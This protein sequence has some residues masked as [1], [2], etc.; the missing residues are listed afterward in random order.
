MLNRHWVDLTKTAFASR[1]G[2]VRLMGE[3]RR[4]GPGGQEP[5]APTSLEAIDSELRRVTGVHRVHYDLANWRKRSDGAWERIDGT[6]RHTGSSGQGA[7]GGEPDEP[8][9]GLAGD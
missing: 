7:D 3:V 8:P 5:L 4:M 6:P 1:R 9:P 2:I